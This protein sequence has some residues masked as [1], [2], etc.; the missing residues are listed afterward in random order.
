MRSL[1]T[2]LLLLSPLVTHAAHAASG[3]CASQYQ[4]GAYEDAA[5][6]FAALGDQGNHSGHLLYN[7]GNAWYR[8]DDLGR[9]VLAWRRAQLYL[10]RDG[11]LLAN[12]RTARTRLKDQLDLPDDRGPLASTLLA[13]YDR[14]SGAEMALLG[15]LLWA[16]GLSLAALHLRRANPGLKPVVVVSLLLAVSL[17]SG[18]AARAFQV[19]HHPIAVVL[20][21]QVTLRSGRDVQSVDIAR[22]HAGAELAVVER[23]DAWVLLALPTGERGW[24]SAEAVGLVCW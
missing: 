18:S 5:S 1:L 14:L 23:D 15:A 19:D 9:A 16:I 6:C 2:L 7:Q 20:D 24:V 13:P 21:D 12:L 4:Q 3:D 17:L 22:L 10:P 11:D 8:A